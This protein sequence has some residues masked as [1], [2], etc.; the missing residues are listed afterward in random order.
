MESNLPIIIG[1]AQRSERDV[2]VDTATSPIDML[3][4]IVREAA[5]SSGG[6]PQLIESIDTIG[7]ADVLG[8]SA[9]NPPR[10]LADAA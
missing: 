8:W 6:A 9:Q 7:L 2:T 3:S 10:L 5:E 1:A 4:R